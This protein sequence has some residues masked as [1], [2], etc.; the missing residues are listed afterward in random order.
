MHS[1]LSR[2]SKKLDRQLA[3]T[4]EYVNS[5]AS[6]LYVYIVGNDIVVLLTFQVEV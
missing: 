4:G 3:F 5:L 2:F 6:F 1:S